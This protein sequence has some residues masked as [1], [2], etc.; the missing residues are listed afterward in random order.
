ER[1][2][3][4]AK[5][6]ADSGGRNGGAKPRPKAYCF[7]CDGPH[8]L[9]NCGNFK[10]LSSKDRLFFCIRHRLCF[11]CFRPKHST[12]ECP[13][14]RPCSVPDCKHW[15]HVLLHEDAETQ[16]EEA[17]RPAAARSNSAKLRTAV[18]MIPLEVFDIDGNIVRANGFVDEGS[19]STLFREGFVRRLRL[20]GS[21]QTLTV[22]G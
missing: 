10:R 1:R 17:A 3:G 16:P 20:Q 21:A 14:K 2:G 6:A 4:G 15:H 8:H 19:D 18:G 7:Q 22:D 9:E 5:P 13:T 12:R 11:C